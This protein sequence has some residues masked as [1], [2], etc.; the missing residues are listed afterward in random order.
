MARVGDR[1]NDG[2]YAGESRAQAKR[3]QEIQRGQARA[4]TSPGPS[5]GMRK[6]QPKRKRGCAPTEH[7][8]RA[9]PS[10]GGRPASQARQPN[11]A[12]NTNTN[13]KRKREGLFDGWNE[14][15]GMWNDAVMV[16]GTGDA[17][18]MMCVMRMGRRRRS[19]RVH[20]WRNGD[21]RGKRKTMAKVN[22]R[23]GP[24]PPPTK[25]TKP[26]NKT[27]EQSKREQ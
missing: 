2:G 15:C 20:K 19:E 16:M 8:A 3:G 23:I 26:T 27:N 4:C 5:T 24:R 9:S 6:S 17:D 18:G 25:P 11:L 13:N 12:R 14:E 10:A 7:P 1:W 21:G 22:E